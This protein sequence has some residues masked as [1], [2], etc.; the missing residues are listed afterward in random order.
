[1]DIHGHERPRHTQSTDGIV[2]SAVG[3]AR[4]MELAGIS[5]RPPITGFLG[6]FEENL[7]KLR[8]S[9]KKELERAKSDRRK[10]V[11]KKQ[12]REAKKLRDSLKEVKQAVAK[13][14]PHCGG[15]L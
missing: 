6:V 12:V 11:I 4:H 10:G 3:C 14:C 5:T 8:T 13:K 15:V 1:M 9:L 2:L 7:D